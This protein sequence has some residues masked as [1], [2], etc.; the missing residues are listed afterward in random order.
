MAEG[1][2]GGREEGGVRKVVLA[3]VV[4][5]FSCVSSAEA[6]SSGPASLDLARLALG[7][8]IVSVVLPPDQRQQML[9]AVLDSMLKNMVGG[10][11]AGLPNL[12]AELAA[13]PRVKAAFERFIARQQSLSGADLEQALPDL[14]EAYARAYARTFTA[15]ELVDIKA[16]VATSSGAKFVQRGPA[17]LADPDVAAWQRRLTAMGAARQAAE[18]KIFAEALKVARK[19]PKP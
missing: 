9:A 3:A 17:L 4:A 2:G 15:T 18:L 6:Q 13:K 16:F 5:L 10:I 19:E 7:R 11:V 12:K 1:E 8:D 14:V